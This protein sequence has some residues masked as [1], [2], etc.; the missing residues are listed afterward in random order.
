MQ[1]ERHISDGERSLCWEKRERER[2]KEKMKQ[3]FFFLSLSS[4]IWVRAPC[5]SVLH[6]VPTRLGSRTGYEGGGGGTFRGKRGTSRSR[7]C[8]VT[9]KKHSSQLQPSHG[10]LLSEV[11]EAFLRPLIFCFLTAPS[12][13]NCCFFLLKGP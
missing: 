12:L 1:N 4:G 6:T 3:G 8:A 2:G 9:D 5:L 10:F 11:N 7:M 13:L